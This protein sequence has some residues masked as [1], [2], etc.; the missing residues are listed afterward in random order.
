MG[1]GRRSKEEDV[2]YTSAGDW[3]RFLEWCRGGSM[4]E[5]GFLVPKEEACRRPQV[6]SQ[7]G[8]EV[9]QGRNR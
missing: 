9:L 6:L 7:D 1:K 4:S 3:S 5:M 2:R 8:R